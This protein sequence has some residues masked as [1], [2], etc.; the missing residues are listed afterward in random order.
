MYNLGNI[1]Q[2]GLGIPKDN[3]AAAEWYIKAA[4]RGSKKARNSLALYYAN[5]LGGVHVDRI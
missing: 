3:T 1:Y 4:G 5:G 2:N